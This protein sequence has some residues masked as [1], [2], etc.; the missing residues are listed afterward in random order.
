MG[1]GLWGGC[2]HC[3][4]RRPSGHERLHHL[5]PSSAPCASFQASRSPTGSL[6][7]ISPPER[8]HPRSRHPELCLHTV[9]VHKHLSTGGRMSSGRTHCAQPGPTHCEPLPA[10]C[11][12]PSSPH[13]PH[14]CPRCGGSRSTLEGL[15]PPPF[16]L[17]PHRVR[18]RGASRAWPR[19]TC[20]CRGALSTSRNR[21]YTCMK[22]AS[23]R[24][25]FPEDVCTRVIAL[26]ASHGRTEEILC[27]QRG[28]G[29]WW[30]CTERRG[31]E[32]GGRLQGEATRSDREFRPKLVR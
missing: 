12:L 6:E 11:Q 9:G 4:A 19:A 29:L 2:A 20:T 14:S 31:G 16:P 13:S 26:T 22:S 30:A 27:C 24:L 18:S 15:G 7:S 21:S 17:P 28:E 8:K 1:G 10:L 5:S 3:P 23:I 32:R 25:L